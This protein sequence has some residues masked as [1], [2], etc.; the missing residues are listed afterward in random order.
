M[1]PAL[2]YY[3]AGEKPLFYLDTVKEL[4]WI[5][6]A[7]EPPEPCICCPEPPPGECCSGCV[8]LF[9]GGTLVDGP[10]EGAS[11]TA[12]LT[13][14]VRCQGYC[15][16]CEPGLDEYVN[17]TAT[18]GESPTP[19]FERWTITGGAACC[20]DP[21]FCSGS[22]PPDTFCPSIA[23]SLNPNP[24]N[25]DGVVFEVACGISFVFVVNLPLYDQDP[26]GGGAQL[27]T[28]PVTVSRDADATCSGV[29]IIP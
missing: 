8:S 1:L 27:C 20:V 15:S 28:V 10:K 4:V 26:F 2:L 21:P 25:N 22:G 3:D 9:I 7:I 23:S 29:V 17:V 13:G 14:D 16:G 5:D 18:C 19:G 6:P 12:V 24:P 11:G